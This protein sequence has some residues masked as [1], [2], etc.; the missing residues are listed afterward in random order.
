M[1]SHGIEP[2]TC[3]V[4]GP[5]ELIASVPA[6][7]GF[8]P[9]PPC[10]VVAVFQ[11]I[12]GSSSAAHRCGAVLR[13]DLPTAADAAMVGADIAS[14]L[15]RM[16][17][18]AAMVIAIAEDTPANRTVV[19][20]FTHAVEGG[21]IRI[22][23]RCLVPAVVGGAAVRC[24]DD[25]DCAG[26][27]PEPATT[28]VAIATAVSGELTYPSRE[29]AIA[30]AR[31]RARLSP[32]ID[33]AATDA[34]LTAACAE[35]GDLEET[36]RRLALLDA[37]RRD[38]DDGRLPAD[39]DHI[40]ALLAALQ[41]RDLRDTCL[42]DPSPAL[43][44]LWQTL[45]RSAPAPWRAAPLTLLGWTELFLTTTVIAREHLEQALHADADYCLAGM[46]RE[47]IDSGTSPS[48]LGELLTDSAQQAR[49]QIT[50]AR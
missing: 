38:A 17:C 9:A 36:A 23:H 44:S 35:P 41:D 3:T 34:A 14:H 6:L 42:A 40:L 31:D 48:Q 39:R 7:L 30:A 20:W 29:A 50:R 21:G 15:T 16:G 46:L 45:A 5:A 47:A 18:D 2:V 22:A 26:T 25:P 24:L 43:A 49:E 10:L 13:I 11:P 4:K 37:A 19:D 28:D 32:D 12:P 33:A 1:D 27:V 8:T